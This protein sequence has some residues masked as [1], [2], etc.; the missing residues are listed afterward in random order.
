MR[1]PEAA[2][3]A[4]G[5]LTFDGATLAY[6]W[7]D[8]VA[9]ELPI[10]RLVAVGELTTANGPWLDDYFL[11]FLELGGAY[12]EASFYAVGRDDVLERLG[13]ALRTNLQPGL[14]NSTEWQ[15]RIIWPESLREQP[16]F[17]LH[18][19]AGSSGGVWSRLRRRLF[20]TRQTAVLAAPLR[21]LCSGPADARELQTDPEGR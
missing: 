3:R 10:E 1:D 16:V 7:P 2:E 9:W 15:T 12:Y 17:E 20:G 19:T 8:R 14:S 4:S 13:A 18:D 21:A 6:R 11:V 5:R